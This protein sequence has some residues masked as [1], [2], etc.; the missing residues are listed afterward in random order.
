[1]RENG[2]AKNVEKTSQTQSTITYF[3]RKK[4]SYYLS[5]IE[6]IAALADAELA[7]AVN[8]DQEVDAG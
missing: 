4:I 6:N 7:V 5:S 1:M 8:P 3:V 2:K